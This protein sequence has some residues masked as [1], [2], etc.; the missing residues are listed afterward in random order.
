MNWKTLELLFDVNLS[1]ELFSAKFEDD[2]VMGCSFEDGVL[3]FY[4]KYDW[5]MDMPL[6]LTGKAKMGDKV[7]I[8]IL[9]HRNELYVN[10][11]L[12]DEEWPY[13][14][15]LLEKSEMKDN[16][17]NLVIGEAKICK[18]EQPCV[19]GEFQNAEGWKPEENVFVG[20][21]MPYCHEG[22][23]HVLYLKDRHH[24]NS[25]WYRGAHQWAH[26]ST[27]DFENWK[28][29][30]MAIEID[31]PGEGSICTGSWI[32]HNNVHYLY[33]TVRRCDDKPASI[34]RS[35]STDGYHFEKDKSFKFTL[36]E[37]YKGSSAR[38]PKVIKDKDG[39]Y[40]MILTTSL[41]ED[42]RGCLAHLVSDDIDTWVEVDEPIYIAPADMGEPECP[43][44]FY[45]DGY[46][47][48]V[49]SLK[50]SG[51]YL[52]SKEQFT[53][54]QEPINP[55]IPCKSV[56]KAAIWNDRL[57]F[58]GFDG[59]GTYGGTLTFLEAKVTE[60]G[61]MIY[62]KLDGTPVEAGKPTKE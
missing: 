38:D 48:L 60:T 53:G 50:A 49:Y 23:Y 30:P 9:P 1:G 55:I 51:Y 12:L 24:H 52:Y 31:D 29:H 11:V 62:Q 59:N 32:L 39:K 45:K 25:K 58:S 56:P 54:W 21:C 28:I 2:E 27:E 20:D 34:C 42:G 7:K 57:I 44:Y 5:F 46:Y 19:I 26:I 17:C 43:D 6:K 22:V 61:E 35:I 8:H 47:Y 18:Q 14:N 33:Y 10:D 4:V 16:G 37:K 41:T 36:S 15:H 13:A 3:N 40:H